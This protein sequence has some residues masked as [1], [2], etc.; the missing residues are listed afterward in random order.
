MI[1]L[2]PLLLPLLL[3]TFPASADGAAGRLA[4]SRAVMT[5][6]L[7]IMEGVAR[8]KGNERLPSGRSPSPP[9]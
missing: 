3:L 9:D 7:A 6:R 5:E 2:L 8:I 4:Q 1:R